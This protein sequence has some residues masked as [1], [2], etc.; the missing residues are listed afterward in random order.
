MKTLTTILKK[1]WEEKKKYFENID[2]YS[3]EIKRLAKEILG[4]DVRIILFG[5][6]VKGNWTPDS[7]IDV[8]IV[9]DKLSKN[10]EENTWIKTKIKSSIHFFSPFQIHLARPEEFEGWYKNFIKDNYVEI[11]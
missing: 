4:E 8:L 6:I 5:S 1:I 10:W 3:K 7:D 2:F 11:E 9:S